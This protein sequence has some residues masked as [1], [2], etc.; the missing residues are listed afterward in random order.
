MSSRKILKFILEE[1]QSRSILSRFYSIT[2]LIVCTKLNYN[3][4]IFIFLLWNVY[5]CKHQK[6]MITAM[7]VYI[8][9]VIYVIKSSYVASKCQH[10]QLCMYTMNF[11]ICSCGKWKWLYVK[12]TGIMN[13]VINWVM[14][15]KAN[16]CIWIILF[17]MASTNR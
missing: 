11:D 2:L 6:L 14:N 12:C 13:L 5:N 9:N 1:M 7:L 8:Y 17:C 15:Y 16:N 4:C 3:T 10:E